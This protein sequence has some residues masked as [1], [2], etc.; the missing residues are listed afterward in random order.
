MS[1]KGPKIDNE[2]SWPT[3][4]LPE[5]SAYAADIWIQLVEKTTDEG[6]MPRPSPNGLYLKATKD[7]H[8]QPGVDVVS[9]GKTDPDSKGGYTCF[10]IDIHY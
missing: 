8:Q 4:K 9:D 2:D 5:T 6:K 10:Y 3:I 7:V 1:I